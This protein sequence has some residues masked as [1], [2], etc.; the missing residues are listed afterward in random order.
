MSDRWVDELMPDQPIWVRDLVDEELR[1]KEAGVKRLR[2][3]DERLT[4]VMPPD[5]KD[6]HQN[7]RGEWPLVAALTFQSLQ[8]DRDFW[9]GEA[10]LAAEEITSWKLQAMGL[11]AEV[12]RLTTDLAR[13][14]EAGSADQAR[15]DKYRDRLR[16]CATERIAE[17]AEVERL[18]ADLATA[19]SA[20][21]VQRLGAEA[22]RAHREV[23]RLREALRTTR[24]ALAA[25]HPT[26][27]LV[28]LLQQVEDAVE[29]ADAAL[30]GEGDD[31][32]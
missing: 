30:A 3:Y 20:T 5:F 12:K 23:V 25:V 22:D 11:E 15:A 32:G 8:K 18:R 31:R 6:W 29:A 7:S 2:D 16:A 21:Y 24:I 1:R 10:E 4:A 9:L 17:Q 19:R 26:I 14:I 13:A 27:T 28:G